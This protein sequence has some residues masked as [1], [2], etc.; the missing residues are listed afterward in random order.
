[1][2]FKNGFVKSWTSSVKSNHIWRQQNTYSSISIEC[3]MSKLCARLQTFRPWTG[4][5]SSISVCLQDRVVTFLPLQ[6]SAAFL[7]WRWRTL[8]WGEQ[9]AGRAGAPRSSPDPRCP[10]LLKD[11]LPLKPPTRKNDLIECKASHHKAEK[12]KKR[13]SGGAIWA[14]RWKR[15]HW[16]R[17]NE[18]QKGATSAWCRCEMWSTTQVT[19]KIRL[20]L[21]H[22]LVEIKKSI[23]LK[24][25]FRINY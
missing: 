5:A 12:D 17:G 10:P 11:P 6:R 4:P 18:L 19:G 7:S 20:L 2:S 15:K 25:S 1:M 22:T 13:E 8:C 14:Q 24:S 23:F 3:D 21:S 16:Q 9:R